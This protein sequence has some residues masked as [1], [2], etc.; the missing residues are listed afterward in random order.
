MKTLRGIVGIALFWGIS[1][2]VFASEPERGAIDVKTAFTTREQGPGGFDLLHF[3]FNLGGHYR[4]QDFTV[5]V[6]WGF[7]W[8]QLNSLETRL[9]G[10]PVETTDDFGVGNPVVYGSYIWR[11]TKSISG[12]VGL[13]LGA[14]A[15]SADGVA[16]AV[17]LSTALGVRSLRD[18][19]LW[20]PSAVSVIVPAHIQLRFT[21][22]IL[23]RFE[24]DA[25]GLFSIEEGVDPEALMQL[26]GEFGVDLG[27]ILPGF[28]AS[29]VWFPTD[30]DRHQFGVDVF[31]AGVFES[32][33]TEL[34]MT[35]NI[36]APAG[37]SF[38]EGVGLWGLSFST[39]FLF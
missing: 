28:R 38:D 4:I 13:G 19:W 10:D 7:A 37:P 8:T 20:T 26:V 30:L 39:R 9:N 24:F 35:F 33:R 22:G 3:S 17:N 15:A 2:P 31:L 25:A 16:R 36:D 6:D 34:T 29:A 11:D 14:P 32:A 21:S 18:A 27:P 12:A 23:L 5:G 1:S